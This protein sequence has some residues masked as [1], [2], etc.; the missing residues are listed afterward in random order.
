M[1]ST[2]NLRVVTV[3][4]GQRVLIVGKRRYYDSTTSV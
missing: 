4:P 1:G 3:R 2:N